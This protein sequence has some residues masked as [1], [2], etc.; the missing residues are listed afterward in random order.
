MLGL[1]PTMI[2]PETE[3]TEPTEL[4]DPS[5]A[6]NSPPQS[7]SSYTRV[8]PDMAMVRDN[9][10]FSAFLLRHKLTSD[11]FFALNPHKPRLTSVRGRPT[12]PLARNEVFRVKLTSSSAKPPS[13]A[14]AQPP[15]SVAPPGTPEGLPSPAGKAPSP[16][17]VEDSPQPPEALDAS[18]PSGPPE[19]LECSEASQEPTVTTTAAEAKKKR[20]GR[21][22]LPRS[23]ARRRQ[24][25][26]ALPSAGEVSAQAIVQRIRQSFKAATGRTAAFRYRPGEVWTVSLVDIENLNQE[27]WPSRGPSQDLALLALE[28]AL[29]DAI[30][31]C[32]LPK[33]ATSR[34]PVASSEPDLDEEL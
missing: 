26:V 15:S 24:E 11:R 33:L 18:L 10:N 17:L 5:E 20:R 2:I 4:L 13:S 32:K 27:H 22:P 14:R 16:P 25:S 30:A 21:A 34:V 8:P 1:S 19:A 28:Q 12:T 6:S 29:V 7:L 3:P 31:R 9:D 23:D